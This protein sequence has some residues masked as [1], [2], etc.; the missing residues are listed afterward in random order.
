MAGTVGGPAGFIGWVGTLPTREIHN[1]F[2]GASMY[3]RI[4]SG[5]VLVLFALVAACSP[6]PEQ[7]A[8]PA[9]QTGATPA[10]STQEMHADTLTPRLQAHMAT[11]ESAQP[12]DVQP[13]LPEHRRLVTA[14]I[15]DCRQMMADMNM[16]APPKWTQLEEQLR[17]DLDRLDQAPPTQLASLMS[18]HRSRVRQ[19]MDM[20][21]SMMGDM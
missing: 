7:Q 15:E 14:M 4:R 17:Q 6:A 12:A 11:L 16:Q 21:N 10:A 1:L 3:N 5:T 19:M 2:K 9:S 13:L 20:R 18:E 8:A